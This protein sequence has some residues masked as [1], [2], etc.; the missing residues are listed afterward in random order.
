MSSPL[1]AIFVGH[2]SPMNAIE[3]NGYTEAWQR[4]GARIPRPSAI[5]AVS[6]HWYVSNT[7][8]TISRAPRTIH[9]FGGFPEA[10][11]QVQYPAPGDPELARRVQG[12][13]APLDAVLDDTWG[14]D[15]GTWSVLRHMYP[16]ADVPVVQLSI[17]ALQPGRFHY[18]IGQALAPLRNENILILGSGNLVH[19]L[20][21]YDWGKTNTAPHDWALRFE[22]QARE[23]IM[24]NDVDLLIDYDGLGPDARLSIPT[25]EHYLPLLYVLGSQSDADVVSFPVAGIEGRSISML[26]VQVGD[27]SRSDTPRV[28]G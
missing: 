2:G 13:L 19:N 7:A 23:L 24:A 28:R 8:L 17:N 6:A 20:R 9:D 3:Q 18:D 15:H 10:L 11:Y 12:L 27:D 5:L 14:L 1:P 26:A 22:Q 25:P 21:L 16:D 4:I